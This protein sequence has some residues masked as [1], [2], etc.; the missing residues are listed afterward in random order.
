MKILLQ[1]VTAVTMDPA[2]P[3]LKDAFVAVEGTKIA[4][5]GTA[6]P[7]GEFDRVIDG[8]G[9]VL[10]PG[11]VNAHTHVAMALLRGYGGGHDLHHWL[12]DYIFPAEDKLDARCVAAGTA[13]GL[14][15]MIASGTTC[16]ADMYMYTDA[17]AK[18]VL[19]A[20]I[21]ANLSCGGVYF[22]KP[23]EFDPARCE[24]CINEEI[25]RDSWHGAGE[26]QILVDASIHAE[27][28]SCPPLWEWTADFARRHGLG[29]QVHIS[30]TQS[31]HENCWKKYGK[32][33]VALL[34]QYGVWE[35][36]GIAAHCVWVSDQ[37]MDI[38][39][40]KHITAVHNPVS[41][42]KLASGVA[43]VPQMLKA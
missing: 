35:R 11:L 19:E 5:V 13:L 10:M 24:D 12:N 28:T 36:G 20:G 42:L 26:G 2:Q 9:K 14:A 43:R 7:Q 6:R 25:L 23:E 4:S 40:Q 22:G 41:N 37:D 39:A 18:T 21:S 30:E 38:M 34:D 3:V 27:Y 1:N 17:I 33:P 29:M 32:T 8:T 31:E 15:E 16:I